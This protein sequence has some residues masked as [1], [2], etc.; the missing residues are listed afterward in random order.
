MA[1]GHGKRVRVSLERVC[2]VRGS[3]LTV[4]RIILQLLG[5]DGGAEEVLEVL[6]HVLLAGRECAR[7]WVVIKVGHIWRTTELFFSL[8]TR[9]RSLTN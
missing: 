1:S 8:G 3:R 9:A 7:L 5:R 2:G 6:E 4:L